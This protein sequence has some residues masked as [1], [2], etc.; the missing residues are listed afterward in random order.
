MATQHD[1]QT[2]SQTGQTVSGSTPVD[3]DSEIYQLH[4]VEVIL[5]AMSALAED[6]EAFEIMRLCEVAIEQTSAVGDR[7]DRLATDL[8]GAR[9]CTRMRGVASQAEAQRPTVGA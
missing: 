4:T 6:Q 2:G 7:L 5:K 8:R 3:F 9:L 1:I